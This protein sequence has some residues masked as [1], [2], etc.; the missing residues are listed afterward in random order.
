MTDEKCFICGKELKEAYDIFEVYEDDK[1][2]YICE[3]HYKE[4]MKLLTNSQ[5]IKKIYDKVDKLCWDELNVWIKIL[6]KRFDNG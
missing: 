3:E 2:N 6:E 1:W 5:L 4:K